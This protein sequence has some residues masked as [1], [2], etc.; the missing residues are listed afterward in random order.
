MHLQGL[1]VHLQLLYVGQHPAPVMV[2]NLAQFI[3]IRGTLEVLRNPQ[4]SATLAKLRNFHARGLLHFQFTG[5]SSFLLE[6]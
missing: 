5:F 2:A 3:G 4:Q 6:V 1:E